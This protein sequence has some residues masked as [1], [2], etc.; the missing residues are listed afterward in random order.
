MVLIK[1]KNVIRKPEDVYII[2]I[3][4]KGAIYVWLILCME[5]G[6]ETGLMDES[7]AFACQENTQQVG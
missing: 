1:I 7:V 6:W 4:K 3:E 5:N 2:R